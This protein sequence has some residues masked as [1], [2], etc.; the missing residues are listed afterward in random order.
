MDSLITVIIVAGLVIF[1]LLFL[2]FVAL[3]GAHMYS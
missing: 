2:L 3:Y 1:T